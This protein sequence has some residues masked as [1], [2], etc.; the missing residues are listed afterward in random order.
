MRVDHN[1]LKFLYHT[2]MLHRRHLE[3]PPTMPRKPQMI[4]GH[5]KMSVLGA[6]GAMVT[7][8]ENSPMMWSL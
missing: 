6:A 1:K 4:L 2:H 8:H 5:R 7:T 3:V